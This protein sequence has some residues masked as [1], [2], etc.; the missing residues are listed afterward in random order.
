LLTSWDFVMIRRF[1]LL[2]VFVGFCFGHLAVAADLPSYHP[3]QTQHQAKVLVKPVKAKQR[4][5][6]ATH[7][8]EK[9]VSENTP[10]VAS[11]GVE[12]E[13]SAGEIDMSWVLDPLV[14]TVDGAKSEG[15]ASVE[16]NLVVLEP[17]Y[18][19]VPS[20]VIE[21]TGHVVKTLRTTAR[22]DVRIGATHRTVSWKADDVQSGRFKIELDAPMVAG[23]LPAYFP[24]SALAMVT[25]EGTSGAAMVSLEKIVLRVGKARVVALQ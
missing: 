10:D 5:V 9:L 8:V 22:I 4:V 21:L 12:T 25:K 7:V 15:S 17:G 24:V 11:R 2:V 23:K 16:G 18:V 6:A 20:M 3:K 13:P 14:A 1:A 19:T